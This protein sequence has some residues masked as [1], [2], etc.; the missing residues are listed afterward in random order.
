MESV[1]RFVGEHPALCTLLALAL[2][3]LA[4][5]FVAIG[6]TQVGLVLKRVGRKLGGNDPVALAGEAGFQADL[7]M[8]GLRFRPWPLFVVTKHPWVQIPADHVGL[9][10][11]QV[12]AALPVGAKSAVY[13][14]EFANFDDVRAF[15]A[16]G[17]EKGVQ[18]PVLAPGTLAPIHPVGFIVVTRGRSFGRP[19]SA[20]LRQLVE[21]L[22]A[23]DLRV[24][25]IEPDADGRD[26]CGIVTVL[27]GPPVEAGDIASRLGGFADIAELEK[28]AHN[29]AELIEALLQ[30]KNHRHNNYQDLQRFLDEG[31]RSGLQHDAL[32]YGAYNLNP[33][34]VRVERVPMLVVEQGEV[35]VVKAYIGLPTADTSGPQFKHGSLV[36]PGH[37]GLWQEP[38]RVGKYMINPRL[39]DPI[40]VPTAILTLNWADYSSKAHDLDKELKPIDAKSREGFRFSIDL[41]VQLH[42]PDTMAPRVIS[43][44]GSM[45]NLVIELLQGAVGNHFRNTLQSMAAIEFIEKRGMVQESASAHVRKMLEDYEVETIGV[46]IQDVDLPEEL[47]RVLKEREIA[48]QEIETFKKKQ[49]AEAERKNVAEATGIA[50]MQGE[51]VRARLGVTVRRDF[52]AARKADAEGEA[53]FL[54]ETGKASAVA[55]EAEGLA[56]ARGYQAQVAALGDDNT[57]R[58]TIARELAAAKVAIVPQVASGGRGGLGEGLIGMLLNERFAANGSAA[59]SADRTPDAGS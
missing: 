36:H 50:D 2:F 18:R 40:K 56:R 4:R 32:P 25:R 58:I 7:L 13:K 38:L 28:Q 1:I 42:V 16:R 59:K 53:F 52:A 24:T 55:V 19:V 14:A 31:G 10:V 44:V 51:V 33:L 35:A 30:N 6:P 43:R 8:P 9:V 11:A 22:G 21:A 46:F 29:D 5:S 34:L 15:L 49:Q 39:Y 54:S 20:E 37:R 45:N 47:T 17:G 27:E 23:F 57:A 41:Q 3:A 26:V 48:N 12:G